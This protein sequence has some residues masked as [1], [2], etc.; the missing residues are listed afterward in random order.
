MDRAPLVKIHMVGAEDEEDEHML[1]TGISGDF[2]E[3][4]NSYERSDCDV[5]DEHYEDDHAEDAGKDLGSD[6]MDSDYSHNGSDDDPEDENTTDREDYGNLDHPAFNQH[7]YVEYGPE[8]EDIIISRKRYASARFDNIDSEGHE[9]PNLSLSPL[10]QKHNP[11]D[12]RLMTIGYMFLPPHLYLFGDLPWQQNLGLSL[13]RTSERAFAQQMIYANYP[14]YLVDHPIH[15]SFPDPQS[16][17]EAPCCLYKRLQQRSLSDCDDHEGDCWLDILK[18]RL[19]EGCVD[20]DSADY[21]E[22]NNDFCADT[23]R[24]RKEQALAHEKAGIRW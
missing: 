3:E 18:A 21:W 15:D 16:Q 9:L 1:M 2:E 12:R 11:A 19:K 6:G 8:D 23:G 20:K 14:Y 24:T 10:A 17:Y 22:C 4:D 5:P 7:L 13:L